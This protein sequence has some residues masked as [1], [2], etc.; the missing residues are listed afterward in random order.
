MS[1]VSTSSGHASRPQRQSQLVLIWPPSVLPISCW[2]RIL[3]YDQAHQHDRVVCRSQ[4][5]VRVLTEVLYRQYR[6]YRAVTCSASST[7][8]SHAVQAACCK[9]HSHST[10]SPSHSVPASH[11]MSTHH[12]SLHMQGLSAM[13]CCNCVEWVRAVTTNKPWCC[14][15]S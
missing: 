12:H 8:L 2:K 6:Q 7:V 4:R 5:A 13:P 14:C 3:W 10:Y 15:K 9:Q 1:R 11:R